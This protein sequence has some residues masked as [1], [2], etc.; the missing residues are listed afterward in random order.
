MPSNTMPE[1]ALVSED[2]ELAEEGQKAT[3]L[4]VQLR[5]SVHILPW[6]R[7]VYAEGN[8]SKIHLDFGEHSFTVTGDGLYSLLEAVAQHRV[9]RLIQPTQTEVK[10]NL[11]GEVGISQTGRPVIKQILVDDSDQVEAYQ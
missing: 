9:L 1:S 2:W 8:S 3:C 6:F 10:M 11:R 7:F 4:V 5:R